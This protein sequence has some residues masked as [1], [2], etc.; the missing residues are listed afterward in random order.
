MYGLLRD[1]KS[2]IAVDGMPRCDVYTALAALDRA[3]SEQAVHPDAKVTIYQ[4]DNTMYVYNS[5]TDAVDLE[6]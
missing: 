6:Y 1:C 5:H 4:W 2:T 3:R